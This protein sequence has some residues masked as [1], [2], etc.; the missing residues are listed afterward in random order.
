MNSTIHPAERLHDP[1]RSLLITDAPMVLISDGNSLSSA[2]LWYYGNYN[3]IVRK[4][5]VLLNPSFDSHPISVIRKSRYRVFLTDSI[6]LLR[7]SSV[8]AQ[9][10]MSYHI[11]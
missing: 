10:L 6:K 11:I 5:F 1:L 3:T 7:R 4:E 2:H 9:S 8:R